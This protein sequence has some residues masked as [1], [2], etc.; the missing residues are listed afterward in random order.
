MCLKNLALCS[1][2]FCAL[3]LS[4]SPAFVQQ[5][6]E[7]STASE[8]S[9]SPAEGP[10][11]ADVANDGQDI[12]VTGFRAALQSSQNI[13]RSSPQI[14]DSVVAEDIGKLPDLNTAE[15]AARIPG[16]QV[17]RQGGEAQNVLVRG[18]PFYTT[19]YNGREI[20]TAETRSLPYRIFP[21]PISQRWKSSKRRPLIWSSRA[22]LD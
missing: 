8:A 7:Q 6:P 4:A 11:Q 3:A 10:A 20:F 15:T 19:T 13:R 22:W 17:Y 21:L 18:L 9:A 1:T 16:V 2:S 12:V 14:V 5:R